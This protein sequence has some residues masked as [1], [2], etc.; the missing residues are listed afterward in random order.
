MLS[1]LEKYTNAGKWDLCFD[2]IQDMRQSRAEKKDAA[3]CDT[4]LFAKEAI[5]TLSKEE[6]M[7]RAQLDQ[8]VQRRLMLESE[9]KTVDKAAPLPP[10]TSGTQ[11]GIEVP[12]AE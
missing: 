3:A 7:I 1:K 8:V 5:K 11:G 6:R 10:F 9:I 2:V 12:G 4:A